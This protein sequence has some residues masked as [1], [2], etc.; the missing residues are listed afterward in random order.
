MLLLLIGN[1]H[2]GTGERSQ[3][4]VCLSSCMQQLRLPPQRPQSDGKRICYQSLPARQRGWL[5]TMP[6]DAGFSNGTREHGR[7]E[8]HWRKSLTALP[9]G[10]PK[11]LR[12]G[13]ATTRHRSHLQE[14]PRL[15]RD[16]YASSSFSFE[17]AAVFLPVICSRGTHRLSSHLPG[18]FFNCTHVPLA[19]G[20]S[21]WT[22]IRASHGFIH[23]AELPVGSVRH[24]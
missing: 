1:H 7:V 16:P 20:G 24:V 22:T 4:G 14:P 21:F 17:N 5:P 18:R 8:K 6:R 13:L 11:K 2:D 3:K 15:Y 19:S 23:E 10:Q 9:I 12:A